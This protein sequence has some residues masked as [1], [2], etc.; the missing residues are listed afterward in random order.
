MQRSKSMKKTE[1]I[2]HCCGKIIGQADYLHIEKEWG[3]F[4]GGKDGEK[5]EI[6]LCEACYDRWIR[7]FKYPPS[8]TEKTEL[9]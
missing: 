8:V 5:H 4:S 6:N 2:C 3:Y 7:T 1:I 9:L